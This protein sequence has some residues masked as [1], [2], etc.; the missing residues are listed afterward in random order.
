MKLREFQSFLSQNV[1]FS[2]V[3]KIFILIYEWL[4]FTAHASFLSLCSRPYWLYKNLIDFLGMR[5]AYLLGFIEDLI[6]NLN[7]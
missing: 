6:L 1:Q 5:E 7:I 2:I 3:F 4:M